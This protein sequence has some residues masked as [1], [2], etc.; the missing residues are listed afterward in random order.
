METI[1]RKAFGRAAALGS[2]YDSRSDNIMSLSIFNQSLPNDLIQTV[3][4]HFS[5]YK[6]SFNDSFEEKFS[7][8]NVEAEL[9]LSVMGGLFKLEGSAK[10]LNEK[11]S[12]FK[13][14]KGSM[15]YNIK[16]KRQ[17]LSL[18][19]EKL[20]PLVSS[21][22]L[23]MKNAT[24]IIV[25]ID[26]GAN[27]V[28]SFEYENNEHSDKKI[29]EGNLRAHMEKVAFSISGSASVK[30]DESERKMGESLA[31][32]FYGD[33]IPQNEDLPNS[34][35]KTVELMKKIPKFIENSN[36]G[37]GVPIEIELIP[38]AVAEKL[39]AFETKIDRLLYE[40]NL[41]SI[42]RMQ[43]ELDLHLEAKQKFND[44]KKDI[45]ENSQYFPD[46]TIKLIRETEQ[47][48]NLAETK[49]RSSLSKLLVGIRSGEKQ[50]NEIEE[51]L[52][53]F[54]K[55]D[56]CAKDIEKF[57][58]E[59]EKTL[60]QMKIINNYKSISVVYLEKMENVEILIQKN[61]SKEIYIMFFSEELVELDKYLYKKNYDC[62][63]SLL[64]TNSV[65]I[66]NNEILFWIYDYRIHPDSSFCPEKKV[67]IKYYKN[68][69][70]I[71]D[72][73]YKNEKI[74]SDR[75]VAEAVTM[76]YNLKKPQKTSKINL[77]CP[78]WKSKQGCSKSKCEWWCKKCQTLIEYDFNSM[79]F[80]ECG[81]T[82]AY[83]Y[84]FMCKDKHHPENEFLKFEQ[85]DIEKRLRG[86]KTNKEINILLLGES[87]VG[88]R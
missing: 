31:I 88:K 75:C 14:V 78:N 87:G 67:A 80:C 30:F 44:C 84:G 37:K 81:G 39:F 71:D 36:E 70:E 83:D 34:V 23:E 13:S 10:Y 61:K 53:E 22:A 59:N 3:D 17:F 40:V 11:K 7:N 58:N 43:T 24:H 49:F 5:D 4:T 79:F 45:I 65:S 26:W 82:Y 25:G 9:K 12:S 20:K 48:I 28:A 86:I 2:L 35:E 27:T 54:Q 18:T 42:N 21:P 38:I 60:N 51:L 6:Y 52:E 1:K 32:K 47:K 33:F 29:I 69:I 56:W 77:V 46:S 57:L 68:G 72:D 62:F 73:L 63:I 76:N 8:L 85:A 15:I 64:R 16:T 74:W 41:E 50:A 66:S 19:N 55:S